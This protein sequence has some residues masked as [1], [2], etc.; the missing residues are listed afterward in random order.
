[1]ELFLT[2][3]PC[4]YVKLKCL[5]YKCFVHLNCVLMQNWYVWNRTICMYKNGFGIK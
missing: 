1:M 2:L 4:T 3:K 5:K